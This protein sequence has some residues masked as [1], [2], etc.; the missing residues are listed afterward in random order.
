MNKSILF[1]ALAFVL[2]L[3]SCGPAA[4]DRKAMVLRAKVFQDS[5]ANAIAA[6]MNEAEAPE[7]QKPLTG[8]PNPSP[9]AGIK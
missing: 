4:E 7:N 5:I 2:I 6:Q 8:A 1:S 9:T 3:A